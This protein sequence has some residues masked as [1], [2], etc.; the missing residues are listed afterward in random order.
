[1]SN[2]FYYDR[3]GDYLWGAGGDLD[4]FI[5]EGIITIEEMADYM[6]Y[7]VF[8][9]PKPEMVKVKLFNRDNHDDYEIVE[10]T[11]SFYVREIKKGMEQVK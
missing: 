9:K 10:V 7:A 3:K 2:I 8:G 4:N 6:Y 1:V 5:K 11:K